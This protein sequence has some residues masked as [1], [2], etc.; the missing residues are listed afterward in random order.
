MVLRALASGA[1]SHAYL[2]LGPAGAGR[3]AFLRAFARGALC[4]ESLD[5]RHAPEACTACRQVSDG[6]HPDLLLVELEGRSLG[7]DAVRRLAQALR[8]RPAAAAR[9]VA[10]VDSADELTA[11]AASALLKLL[12]EPPAFAVLA[13][14]AS[15]P[16][17]L[18]P[19]IIS[20]CQVVALRP[21]T[22]AQARALLESEGVGPEPARAAA[23]LGMNEAGQARA[24]AGALDGEAA[25][26]A[27]ELAWRALAGPSAFMVL[28]AAAALAALER[29]SLGAVLDRLALACRDRAAQDSPG[30]APGAAQT[31]GDPA[32]SGWAAA[33]RRIL[34]TRAALRAPLNARLACEAMLLRARRAL[35]EGRGPRAA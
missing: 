22:A 16:D 30:N 21:G 20:R 1:P 7:I 12:E 24:I 6:S 27:M 5:L 18:L 32:S 11:E 23:Y 25:R 35:A 33:G 31:P 26:A 9:R 3:A 14:A 15:T 34:Q 10:V 13:L 4:P 17:R 8:F 2:F 29:D 28:E 19:T